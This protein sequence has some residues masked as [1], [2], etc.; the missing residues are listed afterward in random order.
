V[1]FHAQ[2]EKVFATEPVKSVDEEGHVESGGKTKE[3]EMRAIGGAALGRI[4]GSVAGDGEGAA[5]GAIIVASAGSV[6][7]QREKDLIFEPGARMI[8][9]ATVPDRE[10]AATRL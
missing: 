10:G 8:V 9:R 4:I 1:A 5:I 7:V 6:Y 2:I 3:A